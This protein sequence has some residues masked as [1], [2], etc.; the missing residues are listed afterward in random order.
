MK[1][2]ELVKNTTSHLL[3]AWCGSLVATV[4]DFFCLFGERDD[5]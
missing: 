2:T 4:R 3:D 5:G 1:R